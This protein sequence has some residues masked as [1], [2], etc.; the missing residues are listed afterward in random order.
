MAS[1]HFLCHHFLLICISEWCT[2]MFPWFGYCR[3]QSWRSCWRN[4]DCQRLETNPTSWRDC[5]MLETVSKSLYLLLWWLFEF[6]A[7]ILHVL[8]TNSNSI[9]IDGPNACHC[10]L[11]RWHLLRLLLQLLLVNLLILLLL[12][13]CLTGLIFQRYSMLGPGMWTSCYFL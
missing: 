10:M 2:C 3:W 11:F 9:Y 4:V 1:N 12:A 7:N 8:T 6:D 5:L 13:F